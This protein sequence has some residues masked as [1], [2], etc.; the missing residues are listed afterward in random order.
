MNST[1]LTAVQT[2]GAAVPLSVQSVCRGPPTVPATVTIL[3][4]CMT[5]GLILTI[6]SKGRRLPTTVTALYAASGM[7]AQKLNTV[8]VTDLPEPRLCLM[9]PSLWVRILNVPGLI[10][11]VT[12]WGMWMF[13]AEYLPARQKTALFP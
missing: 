13:T 2:I 8:P 12:R 4:K 11:R 6:R 9:P 5:A 7:S 3:R 10:R 1:G